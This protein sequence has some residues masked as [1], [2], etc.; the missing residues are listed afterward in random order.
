MYF[1]ALLPRLYGAVMAIIALPW[2]FYRVHRRLYDENE[3]NSI[4]MKYANKHSFHYGRC[5]PV[6]GYMQV[7]QIYDA[8][9]VVHIILGRRREEGPK[10]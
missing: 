9:D 4:N 6:L 10:A 2:R 5:T 8:A 1:T 7:Q 3:Q